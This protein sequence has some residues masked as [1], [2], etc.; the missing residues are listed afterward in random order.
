MKHIF[1][2]LLHLLPAS[3][4]IND[5]RREGYFLRIYVHIKSSIGLLY[6]KKIPTYLNS[7]G[8]VYVSFARIMMSNR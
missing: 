3:Y 7:L 8:I 1:P 2:Y 5:N 4:L 6:V